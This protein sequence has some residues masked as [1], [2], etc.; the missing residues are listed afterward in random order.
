MR[1]LVV[2]LAL[3]ASFVTPAAAETCRQALALG[4]DVSGSVDAKEYQLQ[5]DG[6]A[7]ALLQK[8]VQ[9]AFLAQPNA[10]VALAIYEW[11]GPTDQRLL[12]RWRSIQSAADLE[13]I[14]T[15]LSLTQRLPMDPSTGL[16]ASIS[17]GAT[18]L[19]QRPNCW[20][21]TLDIS[22][23]G[24]SNAGP[25]PQDVRHFPDVSAITINALVIAASPTERNAD[26]GGLVRYFEELVTQGLFSFVEQANGFDAYADAMAQKLLREL[27][28][29]V[30]SW[31]GSK[32]LQK[33]PSAPASGHFAGHAQ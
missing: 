25:R 30:L 14:A 15:Q 10:P 16:G 11:S 4:L 24:I 21:H 3:L 18:L 17:Y 8:D 31:Q 2:G 1:N 9:T 27:S 6:L 13:Q 22:G 26:A 23:D 33:R 32:A 29:M 28:G 20:Q 12:T 7:V 5:L 19:A